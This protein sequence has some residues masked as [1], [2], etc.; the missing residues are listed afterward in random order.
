MCI[1]VYIYFIC[2]GDGNVYFENK[3]VVILDK[4]KTVFVVYF[5]IR[6]IRKR[7][8]VVYILKKSVSC[9]SVQYE[10]G[11]FPVSAEVVPPAPS[12]IQAFCIS[13]LIVTPDLSEAKTL[14]G[15]SDSIRHKASTREITR[16][17]IHFLLCDKYSMNCNLAFGK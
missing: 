7:D 4:D 11:F 10:D 8:T 2:T 14:A 15:T 3:P 6:V 13:Y 9:S 16:F 12:G 17:F 5:Y 1:I